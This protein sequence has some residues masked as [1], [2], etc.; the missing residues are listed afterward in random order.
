MALPEDL[1]GEALDERWSEDASAIYY[2]VFKWLKT[3]I[4]PPLEGQRQYQTNTVSMQFDKDEP[5]HLRMKISTAS[6]DD[7]DHVRSFT[8]TEHQ[9]PVRRR[10]IFRENSA[11]WN[12]TFT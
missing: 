5:L 7:G 9:R 4:S 11:V 2:D 8:V 6:F 1:R 10:V 12:A 3:R